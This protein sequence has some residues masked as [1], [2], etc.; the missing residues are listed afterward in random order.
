MGIRWN[1]TNHPLTET[2]MQLAEQKNDAPYFMSML[3]IMLVIW[4]VFITSLTLDMQKQHANLEA[5]TRMYRAEGCELVG[6]VDGVADL[7][8]LNCGGNYEAVA[9]NSSIWKN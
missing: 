2:V 9:I 5:L 6:P 7:Y 3:L 1:P 4:F 8:L